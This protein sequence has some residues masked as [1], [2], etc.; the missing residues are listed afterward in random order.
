[1]RISLAF[2]LLTSMLAQTVLADGR[3]APKFE[4]ETL[5]GETISLQALL[6]KGPVIIEFWATYC[7]TC[8]EELDL[9]NE[10]LPDLE[11]RGVSVLGIS[12]DSPRNQSKIRP[13]V[14]SRKWKIP[15]PLDPESKV[16]SRYGV[17]TLPTLYIISSDGEIVYSRV[18]YAPT[19]GEKIMEII[20]ELTPEPEETTPPK[21]DP[22]EDDSTGS[23]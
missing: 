18:G 10:L 9:L 16:K 2:A 11:E 19:M 7:K 8:D 12:I 22:C 5:D 6:E 21:P 3:T 14:S 20:A 15:I 1:M 23:Q 13:I 4:L 17:K